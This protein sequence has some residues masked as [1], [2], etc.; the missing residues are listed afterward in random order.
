MWTSKKP[1]LAHLR[2]FGC[3]AYAQ[4]AKKQRGKLDSTSIY[5]IFVGYTPTHRQ[6][7]IYNLK[8][9]TVER[10]STMRFDKQRMGT[11]IIDLAQDRGPLRLEG[12]DDE[13]TI[14]IQQ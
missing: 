6:Y 5:G 2:V 12:E 4:L 10:Y 1:S 7:R 14:V 3:V 9:K 11:T 13:D 8:T